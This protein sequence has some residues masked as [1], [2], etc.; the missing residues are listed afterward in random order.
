MVLYKKQNIL[1]HI[2]MFFLNGINA[3]LLQETALLPEEKEKNNPNI[4]IYQYLP[5]ELFSTCMNEPL[6]LNFQS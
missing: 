1:K 6:T 2:K 4:N 3:T 5:V